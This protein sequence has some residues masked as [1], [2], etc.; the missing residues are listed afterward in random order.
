MEDAWSELVG[1]LR[2]HDRK[3]PDVTTIP[4]S[5][6]TIGKV[7]GRGLG[8][9]R[10]FVIDGRRSLIWDGWVFRKSKRKFQYITV[11]NFGAL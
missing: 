8:Q 2:I 6:P 4:F 11:H 5:S 3:F 7:D 1:H 9:P 10:D